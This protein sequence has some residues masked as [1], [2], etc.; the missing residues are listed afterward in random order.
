VSLDLR[1]LVQR[2]ATDLG[3]QRQLAAARSTLR[4]ATGAKA[5]AVVQQRLGV[6]VPTNAGR[7]VIMRSNDLKTAQDVTQGVKHLAI[8]LPL[9]AFVLF[10]AAIWLAEGRRRRA[11]RTAGWCL[12]AIGALLLLLRRAAGDEVV[13]ALVKV[14]GNS[15]AAHEVWDIATSLMY[16]IAVAMVAYGLVVVTCAWLAG[17]TT[18]A[19]SVRSALAPSVRS[20]LAPTLR[21]EP[22]LVYAGMEG[23][24][25]LTVIWGPTP[26]LRELATILVFAALLAFG[27]ALLRRQTARE[28]PDAQRG[29]AM[30]RLRSLSTGGLR[31]GASGEQSATF[32][33]KLDELERL[34]VLHNRGDLTDE[35]F[36]AE[37]A[38]LAASA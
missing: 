31:H 30:R 23:M 35:E 19:R 36:A 20:A 13:G 29:D 7:L 34:A 26:A 24:L 25:L 4:V 21:D 9:V 11:L 1:P 10:S 5:R 8:V 2:L 16:A 18:A 32:A 37:K 28:Y 27:V 14:P 38:R 12:V 3:L 22:A 17:P 15:P 6:T 33:R